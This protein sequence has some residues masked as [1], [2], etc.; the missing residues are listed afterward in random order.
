VRVLKYHEHRQA[1]RQTIKLRQ[2]CGQ[3]LFLA[4]LRAEIWQLIAITAR[5]RQQIGQES[6][7]PRIR[8]C[9]REQRLEPVELAIRCVVPLEPDSM[10]K[11]M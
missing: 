11:L 1:C 4:F 7:V 10:R 2:Q 8:A 6:R 3:G 5:D 9:P